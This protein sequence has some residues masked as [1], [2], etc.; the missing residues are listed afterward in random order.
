MTSRRRVLRETKPEGISVSLSGSARLNL[1]PE[2]VIVVVPAPQG[3]AL[4]SKLPPEATIGIL[5]QLIAG[6]A[7]QLAQQRSGLI[8]PTPAAAVPATGE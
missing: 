5:G 1:P 8:V 3:F 2:P 4:Q 7:G 6:L